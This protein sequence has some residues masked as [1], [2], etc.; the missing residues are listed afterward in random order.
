M[1]PALPVMFDVGSAAVGYNA[2]DGNIL[3]NRRAMSIFMIG[4]QV[5]SRPG[6]GDD[7]Y[8]VATPSL[9]TKAS[10]ESVSR[11]MRMDVSGLILTSTTQRMYSQRALYGWVGDKSEF[12]FH[13]NGTVET[14]GAQL[15]GDSL[16]NQLPHGTIQQYCWTDWLLFDRALTPDEVYRVI[17]PYARTR[18]VTTEYD[19]TLIV[20]GDSLTLGFK[21]ST[22]RG[23]VRRLA[24]SPRTRWVNIAL[25]GITMATLDTDFALKPQLFV[26]T[27]GNTRCLICVWGGTNDIH[28]G[29]SGATTYTSFTSYVGKAH[30]LSPSVQVVTF[31]ALPRTD[32]NAAQNVE[33]ADY[34]ARILS[35]AAGCDYVVDLTGI[36]ALSNAADT[37]YFYTDG[38]HL[39]DL[40][41]QVLAQALDNTITNALALI[42]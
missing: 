2:G 20:D 5:I 36:A 38:I 11:C 41:E 30:A 15:A 18:G 10:V 35:N 34:N 7:Q 22:G 23:Y 25:S 26:P 24:L 16:F 1:A 33:L 27:T 6:Q 17:L 39:N 21:S 12:R 31:T 37:T 29:V 4:E 42:P 19:N 32:N 13:I 40:G 14:L 9:A 3:L 8:V 28:A